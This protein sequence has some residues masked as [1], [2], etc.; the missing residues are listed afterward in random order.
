MRE[1]PV[2][3][4]VISSTAFLFILLSSVFVP[5]G[6]NILN[7]I[8][9]IIIIIIFYYKMNDFLNSFRDNNGE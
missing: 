7:N 5:V 8:P 2:D 4:C 9:K 3:S 6:F 1:Y